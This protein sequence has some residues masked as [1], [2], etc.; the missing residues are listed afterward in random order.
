VVLVNP[1]V[2]LIATLVGL[3]KKLV[4]KSVNLVVEKKEKK[5]LSI[6]VVD[7]HHLNARD[8]KDPMKDNLYLNS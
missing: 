8:I 7:Q 1:K 2:G 3:I 4:E 6:L 5:D